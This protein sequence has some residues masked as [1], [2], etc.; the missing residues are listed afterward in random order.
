MGIGINAGSLERDLL[1]RYGQRPEAIVESA[2]NHGKI[3]A[4]Y[5]CL[6][7]LREADDEPVP[8]RHAHLG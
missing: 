6:Q 4:D 1:E 3:L 5:R 8:V 7:C 2:L